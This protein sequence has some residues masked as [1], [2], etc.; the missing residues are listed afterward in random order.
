MNQL[1]EWLSDLRALVSLLPDPRRVLRARRVRFV[2][3]VLALVAALVHLPD[4]V[5]ERIGPGEIGVRLRAFGG[6]VE[7]RDHGVGLHLSLCPVDRWVRLDGTTQFVRFGYG[8]EAA[9]ELR[10]ADDNPATCEASVAFRIAEGRAW[11][12][13]ADG[14]ESRYEDRVRS[15]AEDVLRTELALLTSEDWFDT[16]ARRTRV[17]ACRE[18]LV[19][20]CRPLSVELELIA[21]HGVRFSKEYEQELQHK[22]IGYQNKRREEAKQ[23][24]GRATAELEEAR[25]LTRRSIELLKAAGA[26][27]LGELEASFELELAEIESRSQSYEQTRREQADAE[28]ARVVAEAK[29]RLREV[30]AEGERLELEALSEPGGSAWLAVR[31]VRALDLGPVVLDSSRPGLPLPL[32]IDQLAAMFLAAP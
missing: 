25:D 10:T 16:D 22:Q 19:E 8:G 11:K 31:S 3:L 17:D 12:L 14:L 7:Q 26:K 29:R 18:R 15:T 6:G 13:V 23:V 4:A 2:A 32:D 9:L 5:T 1:R 28:Y 24:V 21:V 20:A 30:Q 27:G